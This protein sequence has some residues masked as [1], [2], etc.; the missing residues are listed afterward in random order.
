M[1]NTT[2]YNMRSHGRYRE[3]FDIKSAEATC[4]SSSLSLLVHITYIAILKTQV[5]THMCEGID[6]NALDTICFSLTDFRRGLLTDVASAVLF[7]YLDATGPIYIRISNLYKR[8]PMAS[9]HK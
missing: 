3:S 6:R 8:D 1:N 4:V 7:L 5:C 2:E 9:V